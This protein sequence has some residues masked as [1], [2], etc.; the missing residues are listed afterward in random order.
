MTLLNVSSTLTFF[1][2]KDIQIIQIR[3]EIMADILDILFLIESGFCL[4]VDM[5]LHQSKTENIDAKHAFQ[6][7]GSI[8]AV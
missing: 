1:C 3:S 4:F 6:I 8:R 2:L 5:L 7:K